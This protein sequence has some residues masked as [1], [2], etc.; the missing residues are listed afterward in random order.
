[1]G[2][3]EIAVIIEGFKH[4]IASLKH[5]VS[6]LEET[7]KTTN[8]IVVSIKE[9]NMNMTSMVTEMTKQS[10]RIE[11]LESIP[12]ERSKLIRMEVVKVLVSGSVG[13]VL[14]KLL[15]LM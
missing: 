8:E 9:I 13:A 1:M 3:E 15:S 7:A 4:E 11:K 10:A 6:S 14:A 12:A 5:R 2:T